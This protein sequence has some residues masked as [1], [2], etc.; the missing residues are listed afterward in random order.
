MS[1]DIQWIG[2]DINHSVSRQHLSVLLTCLK[3]QWKNLAAFGN[4]FRKYYKKH[5][6]VGVFQFRQPKLL[7]LDPTLVTDIY[8]KYFKHFSDNTFSDLVEFQNILFVSFDWIEIDG[9]DDKIR[10]VAKPI[11]S[12]NRTHLLRNWHNGKKDAWNWHQFIRC[13]RLKEF[14]QQSR[15]LADTWNNLSTIRLNQGK[16]FYT[17]RTY[18]FMICGLKHISCNRLILNL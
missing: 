16:M 9:F 17:Q 2:I 6:Y 8:V 13:W 7:I 4:N 18:V 15:M 11:H 3:N 1:S 10:Y 5:R 12:S 14:T